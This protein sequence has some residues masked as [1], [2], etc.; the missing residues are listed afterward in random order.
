MVHKKPYKKWG[1]QDFCT[2]MKYKMGNKPPLKGL[3]T[4]PSKKLKA[5][6]EQHKGKK[7]L[8]APKP[9]TPK[10]DEKLSKLLNGET[11][12]WKETVMCGNALETQNIFLATKLQ[13][14]S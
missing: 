11:A 2:A 8:D 1:N 10:D 4:M 14:A 9:W 12:S 3:G 13:T 6:C 5:E 7:R